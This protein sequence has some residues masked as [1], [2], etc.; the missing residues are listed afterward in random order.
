MTIENLLVLIIFYSILL[1]SD[2]LVYSFRE[3]RTFGDGDKYEEKNLRRNSNPERLCPG[4]LF[5]QKILIV[6]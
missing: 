4:L 2:K 1:V 3:F 5:V 6:I